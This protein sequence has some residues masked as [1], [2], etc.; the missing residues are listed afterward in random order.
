MISES[1]D[2]S[3]TAAFTCTNAIVNKLKKS[4]KDSL[5]KVILWSDGCSSQFRSK[6]VCLLVA[7]FVNSV[8]LEQHYNEN[9]H[10]KGTMDVVGGTIKG[11]VF[12]LVKSNKIKINTSEEFA[13]EASKAMP[14]I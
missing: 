10:E 11:M 5:K 4:M 13:T 12:G 9:H 3:R 8:Q 6:Y 14:S 1:S 7:H 2:H